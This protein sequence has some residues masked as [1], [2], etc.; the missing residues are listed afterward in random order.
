MASVLYLVRPCIICLF[1]IR[2]I[3][4]RDTKTVIKKKEA[5]KKEGNNVSSLLLS[6]EIT[7]MR[8]ITMFRST[9]D[10]IYDGGPVILYY[11]IIL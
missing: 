1:Q 5:R 4:Q 3:Q 6:R 8:R 9:T 10:R 11:N 7:V 2:G